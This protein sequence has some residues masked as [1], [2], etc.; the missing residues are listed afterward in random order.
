MQMIET[1]VYV[2]NQPEWLLLQSAGVL[3]FSLCEGFLWITGKHWNF[4]YMK[5]K[6]DR[7]D[8]I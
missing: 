1:C 7:H 5:L 8:F 2:E 4:G 3:L 6:W